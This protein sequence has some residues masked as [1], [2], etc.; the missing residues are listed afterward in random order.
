[1]IFPSAICSP[2]TVASSNLK[3]IP[4]VLKLNLTTHVCN[5]VLKKIFTE[6]IFQ[7]V[8]IVI[9]LINMQQI[10]NIKTNFATLV[11]N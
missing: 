8:L 7:T 6:R 11:M 3:D 10:L 9:G 4:V 1:M 2:I 5:C